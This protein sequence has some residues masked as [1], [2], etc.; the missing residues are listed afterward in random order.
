MNAFH[1][2]IEERIGPYNLQLLL[3]PTVIGSSSATLLEN[4]NQFCKK[5]MNQIMS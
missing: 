3:I 5:L 2:S 1:R 4:E